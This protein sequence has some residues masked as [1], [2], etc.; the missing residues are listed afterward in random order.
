MR[1]LFL[2]VAFAGMGLSVPSVTFAETINTV[3][4]ESIT[5]AVGSE[6]QETVAFKLSGPAVPR[7]FSIKGDN[8]RVVIDFPG[9]KY[10]GKNG[11]PLTDGKLATAIR[12]GLHQTPEQKTRIVIDLAKDPVV[13]Y[14][15]DYSEADNTFT[16]EL[17]SE[18]GEPQKKTDPAGRPQSPKDLPTPETS[19]AG[20][21]DG[22]PV[23]P[24]LP[25]RET[26]QEQP[27][28]ET[29]NGAVSP[30][31]LEISFDDSS[32]KGEMVLFHLNDFH[33]PAVSAVEKENP[34]V[35]CDFMEM[36]LGTGVQENILAN[37]KYIHR[38]HTTKH[39]N[40]DKV[41]VVLELSPDRDYDL[42]QVFFKNDNLFVL[43][44]NELPPGNADQ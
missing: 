10:L 9:S 17:T 44:V 37:G 28:Q 41:Q 14:T 1:W 18:A 40:P 2:L 29:G 43:I 22:K 42:Q 33:P 35:L 19:A 30:Q 36:E 31:L 8:P 13:R 26:K 16:V 20:P 12:I 15:H 38:I 3:K 24:V 5:H 7:I 4:I 39:T 25:K 32:N 23:P 11:I 21:L 34:R 27:V 6:G